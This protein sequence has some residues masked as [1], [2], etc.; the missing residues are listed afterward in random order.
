MEEEESGSDHGV[1]GSG[2]A[3]R[4]EAPTPLLFPHAR[5]EGLPS[6]SREC[7]S[8]TDGDG[9]ENGPRDPASMFSSGRVE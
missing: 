7:V 4:T 1:V 8:W 5:C 9:G 3:E 2:P 6:K